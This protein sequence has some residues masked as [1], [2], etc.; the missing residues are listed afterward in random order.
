MALN[1]VKTAQELANEKRLMQDIELEWLV[2]EPRLNVLDKMRN[3]AQDLKQKAQII[4][5]QAAL[6]R[7]TADVLIHALE[8]PEQVITARFGNVLDMKKRVIIID[9]EMAEIKRL[10]DLAIAQA[11]EVIDVANTMQERKAAFA[12]DPM[13]CYKVDLSKLTAEQ[14]NVLFDV[15]KMQALSA[16]LRELSVQVAD[17]NELAS[18]TLNKS[19]YDSLQSAE[20]KLKISNKNPLIQP[21]AEGEADLNQMAEFAK[22]NKLSRRYYDD[23]VTALETAIKEYHLLVPTRYCSQNDQR[24]FSIDTINGEIEK[25]KVSK[26]MNPVESFDTLL[27]VLEKQ[28]AE[29]QASH[30]LG[31]FSSFTSSALVKAYQK[32]LA[33]LPANILEESHNRLQARAA[34]NP[35][36][37]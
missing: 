20:A 17:T 33:T 29:T 21:A 36:V 10:A 2:L 5:D 6:T 12:A 1:R 3:E 35:V 14:K 22:N 15:A 9:Q 26:A 37:V 27:Q 31:L 34:N 4:S 24:S 30:Q 19:R 25:L 28:L 23:F 18:V 16:G 13:A 8:E 11:Q 7:S 32:A